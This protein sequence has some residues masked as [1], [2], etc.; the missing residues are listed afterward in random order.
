MATELMKDI[1][2]IEVPLPNNPMKLLNSYFIRGKERNLII[3]TGFNRPECKAALMG[4][5]DELN[6][7]FDSTDFFLT[8]LHA[9]HS[10]LLFAVKTEKNTAYAEKHEAAVVNRL[11]DDTYWAHIFEEF[12]KAGL[13][14]SKEMA[15]ST[16]PGVMWRPEGQVDF[17]HVKD[18]QILKIG[19][20]NLRCVVTPGHSPGHT[21]LF[22]DEKGILFAGDMILGDITPNLCYELY[23]D[24]PL[25]DY[26]NSL[27][28]VENLDIKKIFVGHRNMLEDVYG[29]IHSL[30]V[31]HT[32]R[33]AEALAALKTHGPLTS[34]QA[35]EFMT[36]DID[37]KDW[38]A[39]PPSQKWFATGEAD[40]HMI[41]LYHN[42]KVRMHYDDEG[43]K[44]Y[45]FLD[46][47]IDGLILK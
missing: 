7:D 10:G 2:R 3:D 4:A 11:H 28:I 32:R 22:D 33:C 43:V 34:W 37:A 18:G 30:R 36:W 42:D 41:F 14:L 31:H 8:H 45:E 19:D 39:F 16:H 46:D 13:K 15:I 35:A 47:N 17:T 21:C 26:V 9:D 27:T 38:N 6:A 29:R 40:A 5:I 1:Y 12:R 24:D 25:T 20:Y 23:L 44:I